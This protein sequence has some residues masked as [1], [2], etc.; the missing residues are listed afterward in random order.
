MIKIDSSFAF[1]DLIDLGTLIVAVGVAIFGL[2]QYRSTS[3]SDF[4]K[5]LREAQLKLYQDASSAAAQIATL[6]KQTSEWTKAKGDFLTL[7]YGP[8]AILESFEHVAKE[9]NK[10]LSVEEAMILFKSCMDDEQQCRVL[11]SNLMNLSL[12]LAHTC[13]E[14]LGREWGRDLNQLSGDY[15]RLAIEYRAKLRAIR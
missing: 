11:G 2:L 1:K 15:Q 9:D 10:K 14:E 6:Q 12:A 7:Y 3:R 5:P 8:M 4:I 13:R